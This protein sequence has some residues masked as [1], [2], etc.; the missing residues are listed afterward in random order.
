MASK[1]RI[2]YREL[3]LVPIPELGVKVGDLGVVDF[4]YDDG[5]G[6]HVEIGREDGT[7]AGFVQLEANK[8]GAWHVMAYSVFG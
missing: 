7:S 3:D 8:A 4:I 6:L 5:R 2:V 1:T